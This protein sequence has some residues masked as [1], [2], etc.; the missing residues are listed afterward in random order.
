MESDRRL[1]AVAGGSAAVVATS[2]L[3]AIIAGE[4]SS[5]SWVFLVPLGMFGAGLTFLASLTLLIAR[6]RQRT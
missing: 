2:V 5:L 3:I 4:V 1:L 6:R